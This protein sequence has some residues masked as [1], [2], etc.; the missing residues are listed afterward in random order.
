MAKAIERMALV[1]CCGAAG[2][3]WATLFGLLR[4]Q[5]RLLAR[6]EALESARPAFAL[7]DGPAPA[8][9]LEVGAPIGPFALP[10]LT[11]ATV[12]L[13]DLESRRILLVHWDPGC[14][15]CDQ[16]AAP[17]AALEDDLAR[18]GTE[19]V[20]VSHRSAEE[21][22]RC[23]DKAGLS[24]RILLQ[25]QTRMDAFKTMGTP[26]AYLVDER[27]RV[28]APE[29]VG[30]EAVLELARAAARGRTF[31]R[32]ER[33]LSESRIVRDGLKPGTP[34]PEFTLPELDGGSVAL[35]DFRGRRVLLVFTDPACGPCDELASELAA[36]CGER[37]ADASPAIVMV[38]RGDVDANRRKVARY[39]LTLPVLLQPGWQ[40]SREYGIF[41]TPV[42]FLISEDGRIATHVA[43]GPGEVLALA[44]TPQIP[45][46]PAQRGTLPIVF[47]EGSRQR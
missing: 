7:E 41:A 37:P 47:S 24:C 42:G 45:G 19:L 40:L 5:G 2:A 14:G 34:A 18:H 35:S 30:A 13:E 8:P 6:I 43:R 3:A 20:L 29:A 26:V 16:I 11:A 25:E 21:N 15:F 33:P 28:T 22:R 9:R 31:L 23:A 27:R 10:D 39:G 4:Q 32:S 1:T 17:L 12:A 36:M 38:S 46:V 44:R